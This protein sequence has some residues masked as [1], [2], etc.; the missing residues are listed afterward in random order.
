MAQRKRSRNSSFLSEA[1]KKSTAG[2][3]GLEE[4]SSV[5]L[6]ARQVELPANFINDFAEELIHVCSHVIHKPQKML[7]REIIRGELRFRS[8][9]RRRIRRSRLDVHTRRWSSRW[10]LFLPRNFVNAHSLANA[11]HLHRLKFDKRRGQFRIEFFHV[12]V[13]DL[14]DDNATASRH[15]FQTA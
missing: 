7:G 9:G 6:M 10:F 1:A 3:S 5:C 4:A 14:A 12:F 13:R 15:A 11:F 8:G 2:E